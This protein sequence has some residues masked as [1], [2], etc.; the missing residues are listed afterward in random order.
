MVHRN[1]TGAEDNF[2]GDG[3]DDVVPEPVDVS[4]TGVEKA[5]PGK[6]FHEREL[7]VQESTGEQ[8]A[9]EKDGSDQVREDAG[10]RKGWRHK[11]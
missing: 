9:Q 2:L 7:P 8:R 3:G 1:H 6:V 11:S 4:K 5:F 10:D